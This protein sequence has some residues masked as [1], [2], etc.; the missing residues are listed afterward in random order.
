M[1]YLFIL[2]STTLL[3]AC[4][5]T[6]TQSQ[7]SENDTSSANNSTVYSEKATTK[8]W[9]STTDVQMGKKVFLANCA[10]CHGDQAQGLV[11]DWKQTLDNGKYPAPPLNGSA[12]AWHHP[13]K[14]LNRTIVY[15]GIPLGGTMPGFEDKLS[16][17][18]R[19][20]AIAYFQ[21]FWSDEIYQAWLNRG[22][23]K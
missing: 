22:G 14:I 18:E 5:D 19:L 20:Q 7:S 6:N 4:T 1:K 13:L 9:Y 10:A 15:G 17:T 2:L 8:R 12:H 16:Q 3:S 21:N 23:L 11:K